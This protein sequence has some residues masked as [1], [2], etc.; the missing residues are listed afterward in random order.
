[1]E[2]QTA[3]PELMTVAEV[4]RRYRTSK[5]MVYR[6]V[7]NGTIDATRVGKKAIRVHGH[8]ARAYLEQKLSDQ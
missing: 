6:L 2:D 1:V 5:M 3:W 4:A 8:S 7:H